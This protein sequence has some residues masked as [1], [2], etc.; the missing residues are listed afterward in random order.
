MTRALEKS[1][2]S[3]RY[4]PEMRARAVRMVLEHQGSYDTQPA[5]VAAFVPEIGCIAK[6]LK[7]WIRQAERD[8]SA[9][10]PM[11]KH[12]RG[13]FTSRLAI[14]LEPMAPSMAR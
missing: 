12:G 3:N 10:S 11:S 14:V 5:A 9:T 8:R 7:I 1:K 6:T 13:L 4:S 2:I